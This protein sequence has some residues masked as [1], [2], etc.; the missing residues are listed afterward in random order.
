LQV[1]CGMALQ[2]VLHFIVQVTLTETASTSLDRS[3]AL[4]LSRDVNDTCET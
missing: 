3:A 1:I 2:W 4:V